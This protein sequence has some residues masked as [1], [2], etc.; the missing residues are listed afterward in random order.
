MLKIARAY[1]A[2]SKL[3]VK[4]AAYHAALIPK[5]EHAAAY[6]WLLIAVDPPEPAP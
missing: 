3:C 4:L 2:E 5:Y 6:P 1:R